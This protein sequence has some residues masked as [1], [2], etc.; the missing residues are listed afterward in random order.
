M[1]PRLPTFTAPRDAGVGIVTAIFL[2]VVL[3]ALG[4][5]MVGVF[6][7]QVV[8]SSVD[9]QGARAYQAARAGLEW[10]IF[11]QLRNGSC[12]ASSKF[13]LPAG[14][15]LAPFTVVVRCTASGSGSLAHAALSA[16]SCNVLDSEGNCNCDGGTSNC[17]PSSSIDAV[18]RRVDV[19]L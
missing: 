5:A 13:N 3:A 15:T 11:Q 7:A 17:T 8:S 16:V 4:A 18:S 6:N 14:T 9:L 10:G 1:T 12:A 2:L 19:Q